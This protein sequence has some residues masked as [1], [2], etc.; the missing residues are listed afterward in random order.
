MGEKHIRRGLFGRK[1]EN[2]LPK[3]LLLMP[4]KKPLLML[5]KKPLPMPIGIARG[6]AKRAAPSKLQKSC[7][8]VWRS[9]DRKHVHGLGARH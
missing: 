8:S 3:K 7:G 5:P 2:E 6:L 1:D 9:P 4:P